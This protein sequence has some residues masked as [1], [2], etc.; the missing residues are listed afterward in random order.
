MLILVV[1][2]IQNWCYF[3]FDLQKDSTNKV[4]H[5]IVKIVFYVGITVNFFASY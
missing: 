5:I 3:S 1:I 4:V 2:V